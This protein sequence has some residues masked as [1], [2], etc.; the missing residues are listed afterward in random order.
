VVVLKGV[1]VRVRARASAAAVA[2]TRILTV[3]VR[4][5]RVAASGWP[6]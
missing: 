5:M 4:R 3:A 1:A 2:A 6:Q